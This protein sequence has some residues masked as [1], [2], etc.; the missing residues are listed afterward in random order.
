M[1]A[2]AK[3]AAASAV[4]G[5]KTVE[6]CQAYMLL[7][8]FSPPSRKFSDD[9]NYLFIGMA[10]RY[11]IPVVISDNSA[12]FFVSIASDLRLHSA[13]YTYPPDPSMPEMKARALLNRARV[14]LNCF[15]TDRSIAV[16][17]GKPIVFTNP[18]AG[19]LE[20]IQFD[21][22]EWWKCSPFNL[23][24]DFYVCAYACLLRMVCWAFLFPA[25]GTADK[26]PWRCLVSMI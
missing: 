23:P 19:G 11:Y 1:L 25:T 16:Q 4:N 21:I 3:R 17:N 22:K 12:D 10:L 6:T 5:P 8:I 18:T 15:C 24:Q 2:A 7:G 13:K 26:L 14:W 20:P 9:R